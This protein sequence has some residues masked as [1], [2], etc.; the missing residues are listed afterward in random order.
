MPTMRL[1]SHQ[2]LCKSLF[3]LNILVREE[4]VKNNVVFFFLLEFFYYLSFN[5]IILEKLRRVECVKKS[6]SGGENDDLT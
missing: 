3:F 2:N 5:A 4:K 6:I 1:V